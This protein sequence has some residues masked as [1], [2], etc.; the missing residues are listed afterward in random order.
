MHYLHNNYHN[1]YCSDG[2]DSS[3]SC[4]LL[5]IVRLYYVVFG[6]AMHW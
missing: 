6:S 2:V 5:L 4:L 1:M 3:Q